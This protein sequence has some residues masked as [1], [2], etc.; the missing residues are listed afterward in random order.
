M[1]TELTRTHDDNKILVIRIFIL[2]IFLPF[3]DQFLKMKTN[4][5]KDKIFRGLRLG[6]YSS[7]GVF[8][9]SG[10]LPGSLGRERWERIRENI[11]FMSHY[12]ER[13]R[14]KKRQKWLLLYKSLFQV[15]FSFPECSTREDVAM[16]VEWGVDY[17]KY[18]NCFPRMVS[19]CPFISYQPL[20]IISAP[21]YHI[22]L[23]HDYSPTHMHWVFDQLRYSQ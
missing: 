12:D 7:A 5:W 3:L 14:T 18:D 23:H 9:C 21:S 4:E 20:H 22:S 17:L 15:F 16:L 2:Q 11:T 6:L 19:L 13:G 8:T 10:F 1:I